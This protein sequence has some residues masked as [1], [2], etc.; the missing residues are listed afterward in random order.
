MWK[1]IALHPEGTG[2]IPERSAQYGEP[3]PHPELYTS[4]EKKFPSVLVLETS[5][6]CS[7]ARVSGPPAAE[8]T[9]EGIVDWGARSTPPHPHPRW[10]W[11]PLLPQCTLTRGHAA[12]G[13]SSSL[14]R[15]ELRAGAE[16]SFGVPAESEEAEKKGT[17]K[18]KDEPVRPGQPRLVSECAH[19][20][21]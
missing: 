14:A 5:R 21:H 13:S 9:F 19:A 3:G 8:H 2:G 10:D 7:Y 1:E 15:R 11:R 18:A 12:A 16:G 17:Q 4:R 20:T 6:W